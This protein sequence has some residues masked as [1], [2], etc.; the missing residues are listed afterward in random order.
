[1][2][3]LWINFT[4]EVLLPEHCGYL[5]FKIKKLLKEWGEKEYQQGFIDGSETT[6]RIA[7]EMTMGVSQWLEYGKNIGYYDYFKKDVEEKIR[8]DLLKI[9]DEGEIEDLR[10]EIIKYFNPNVPF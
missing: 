6:G 4:K 9:A 10:R 7:Q 1:M 2:K 5:R 3:D 8:L